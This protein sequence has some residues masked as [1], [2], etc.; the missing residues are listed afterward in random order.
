MSDPA[1]G[2]PGFWRRR[3][4]QARESHLADALPAL[5]VFCAVCAVFLDFVPMWDG[6][7]YFDCLQ[8]AVTGAPDAS[9]DC[10]GHPTAA[11]MR[12]LGLALHLAPDSYAPVVAANA[13]LGCVA[14]VAFLRLARRLLPGAG[15]R[16]STAA[17]TFAFAVHP[18]F[19]ASA[20]QLSPDY[21][22]A[23]FTLPATLALVDGRL[24]A[25]A[26]WSLP[27]VF[28][29]ESGVLLQVL[30]A[31]LYLVF[32]VG[33]RPGPWRDKLHGLARAWP[34]ALPAAAYA[35]RLLFGGAVPQETA[36]ASSFGQVS[37]VRQFLSVSF[38]DNLLPAA[39]LSIL[40]LNWMWL[41]SLPIAAQ[42]L[43][44][45][46]RF[47][48][49]AAAPATSSSP[50]P[51]ADAFLTWIFAGTLF[52]LTRYRTFDNVRYFLPVLAPLM[53]VSTRS[54][55]ALVPWGRLR[56]GVLA[57]TA[58]LLLA[59]GFRASDPVTTRAF[60]TFDFGIRPML[61]MTSITREC[62]GFGRDQLVYNLEFAKL[63]Y[64]TSDALQ[65]LPLDGTPLA[66][67]S[68][69]NFF[70]VGPL[71][72]ATHRRSVRRDALPEPRWISWPALARAGTLPPRVRL[73]DFPN[74]EPN[75]NAA[76][77]S[78]YEI[79]ERHLFERDGYALE[80]LDLALPAQT[81]AAGQAGET[82]R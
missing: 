65:A 23:V 6:R 44:A 46:G 17:A 37:L 42:M 63:H 66:C 20:V 45:T 59:S 13:V 60:G 24:L 48:V 80:V 62:C 61:R 36:L 55:V 79:A 28:S 9:W 5:A 40:V 52:V 68:L 53:L 7:I 33:R 77:L 54:L 69:A 30:G 51:A 11:Y 49:G 57:C 74:F 3:I 43:R 39:L 50:A 15:H 58:V 25:S 71:D 8:K 10:A 56:T 27:A 21:G 70:L 81:P 12:I 18:V 41:V 4:E 64:L 67:H 35:L 38:L 29:K 14:I 1:S 2:P 26:L 73:F 75:E 16:W 78:R 22:V 76:W 19:L 47:V 72:P 34:L 31:L 82:P 32:F